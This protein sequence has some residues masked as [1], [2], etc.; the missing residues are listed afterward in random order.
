M[1]NGFYEKT[2]SLSLRLRVGGSRF[3]RSV[4]GVCSVPV[5]W[6]FGFCSVAVQF[7]VF[8]EVIHE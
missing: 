1:M 3:V 8:R 5:R 7:P 6:T 2:P 4:F